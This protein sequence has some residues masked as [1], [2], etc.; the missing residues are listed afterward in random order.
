MERIPDGVSFDQACWVEPVNTCLKGVRMLNLGAMMSLPSW[1]G[2]DRAHF[3]H[4]GE[5][6]GATV[7]SVGYTFPIAW[8]FLRRLGAPRLTRARAHLRRS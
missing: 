7:I 1:A 5:R 3:H 4:A 6:T 2:A 8:S